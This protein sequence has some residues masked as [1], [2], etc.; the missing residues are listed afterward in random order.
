MKDTLKDRSLLISVSDDKI[1]I[2]EATATELKNMYV[3]DIYFYKQ[4]ADRVCTIVDRADAD[5][6]DADYIKS[7]GFAIER[8]GD[9]LRKKYGG[10]APEDMLIPVSQ[11]HYFLSK[12]K[13]IQR[14]KERAAKDPYTKLSDEEVKVMRD[15]FSG[16]LVELEEYFTKTLLSQPEKLEA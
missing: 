14:L 3:G 6:T 10:N 13:A 2:S 7:V 4:T 8:F 5:Y 1:R 15:A 11:S 12:I 9:M 16:F